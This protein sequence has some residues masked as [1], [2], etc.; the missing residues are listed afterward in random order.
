MKSTGN[1]IFRFIFW[2][3]FFIAH[4]LAFGVLAWHL[5]AQV[6]FA[7]PLGYKLLNLQK[8]IQ[9]NA[10]NNRF[11]RE[12]EFTTSQEHWKLFSQIADAIQHHGKGLEEIRY[13][14]LN[15]SSTPLMHQAEIIHL[16]DV[17]NL[18]DVVYSVGIISA[19]IWVML[20]I[21]AYRKKFNFP[22]ITK[23]LLGFVGS[24]TLVTITVLGTGATRLFYWLHT[25]IFPDGHQWFFYYE[26]SLMTTLM[27]APDIFAF[28]AL[29]L[30]SLLTVLWVGSVWGINKLLVKNVVAGQNT[31]VEKGNRLQNK[32]KNNKNNKN[33]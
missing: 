1:N 16:Q 13:K 14:L 8:H 18:I 17:A 12:F 3:F 31:L 26:D 27:K 20:L 25:K 2:P 29:F 15:G 11:K 5:A 10:P 32:N 7:Y 6:D 9:E 28:I 30:L 19:V 21:M 22:S 24:L 23:I 33:K 4:L